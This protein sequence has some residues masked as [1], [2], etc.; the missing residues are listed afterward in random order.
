MKPRPDAHTLQIKMNKDESGLG[1]FFEYKAIGW[2]VKEVKEAPGQPEIKAGDFIVEIDGE[3]LLKKSQEEQIELAKEFMPATGEFNVTIKRPLMPGERA[4]DTSWH[5]DIFVKGLPP[6]ADDETLRLHFMQV[7]EVHEARLF[8]D[9]ITKASKRVGVVN[10]GSRRLAA[11]AVAELGGSSL[12]GHRLRLEL[13][14]LNDPTERN[15]SREERD[16][17]RAAKM[18]GG[19]PSPLAGQI[20]GPNSGPSSTGGFNDGRQSAGIR[21]QEDAF[22][23]AS[24]RFKAGGGRNMWEKD[25][26]NSDDDV[27][28]PSARGRNGQPGMRPGPPQEEVFDLT[29]G[30]TARPGPPPMSA[31][32]APAVGDNSDDELDLT[33]GMQNIGMGAIG[34][35]APA[36]ASPIG[37][38]VGMPAPQEADWEAK[39][40]G[41]NLHVLIAPFQRDGWEDPA[42]W[43]ILS[44]E[45]LRKYGCGP[46]HI[47][48]FRRLCGSG[49]TTATGSPE[50]VNSDEDLLFPSEPASPPAAVTP[51][52][53]AKPKARVKGVWAEYTDASGRNYYYHLRKKTTTYVQPACFA[54]VGRV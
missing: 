17:E 11:Q 21:G 28:S 48:R 27:Q 16:A 26:Y 23:A 19:R 15:K 40:K 52:K 31:P 24:R 7:G 5:N 39:L 46:G 50:P 43:P 1:V 51:V 42:D 33:T 44:D 3:S 22:A 45:D 20:G 6:M 14:K 35:G 53:K 30:Q 34:M 32:G 49:E 4:R 54:D 2:R 37:M 29:S 9:P 8:R 10:Y 13:D 18:M 47:H 41:A 12:D 38:G 36:A 25:G